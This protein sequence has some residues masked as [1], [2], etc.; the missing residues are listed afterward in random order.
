MNATIVKWIGSGG[1]KPE[2]DM[3]SMTSYDWTIPMQLPEDA[4]VLWVS[5][6]DGDTILCSDMPVAAG[7]QRLLYSW[8][9]VVYSI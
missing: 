1:V 2:P 8:N 3:R 6:M 5:V 7:P 9:G 4:R